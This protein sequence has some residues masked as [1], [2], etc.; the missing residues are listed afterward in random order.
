MVLPGP[1]RKNE[2]EG[3]RRGNKV[4]EHK[5]KRLQCLPKELMTVKRGGGNSG[6]GGCND[7]GEGGETYAMEAEKMEGSERRESCCMTF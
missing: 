7:G 3:R 6:G 2:K 4:K 1:Q 5:K